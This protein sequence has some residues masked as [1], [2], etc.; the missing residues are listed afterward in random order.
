MHIKPLND[1]LIIQLDE[2]QWKDIDKPSLIKIPDSVIGRYRKRATTGRI[3]S[4]GN[5][6]KH[7]HKKGE[8]VY[9]KWYDNRPGYEGIRF[10][11]EQELLA[12]EDNV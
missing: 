10:V 11:S 8:R 5:D 2:D 1:I 3:I 9:F 4:W 6:C 12:K 7:K